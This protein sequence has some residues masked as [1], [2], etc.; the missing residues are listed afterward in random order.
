M[1]G[2]ATRT[3]MPHTAEPASG[4]LGYFLND[5][6]NVTPDTNLRMNIEEKGTISSEWEISLS[7]LQSLVEQFYEGEGFTYKET[8]TYVNQ[9]NLRARNGEKIL[10]IT[11]VKRGK[12][13]VTYEVEKVTKY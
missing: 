6:Y 7:T 8:D 4:S 5:S 1:C 12:K 11:L 13:S 2:I 9:I 10:N 3:T